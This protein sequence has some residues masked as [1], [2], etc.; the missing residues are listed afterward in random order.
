MTKCGAEPSDIIG[1]NYFLKQFH[2]FSDLCIMD[3]RVSWKPILDLRVTSDY[4][5]DSNDWSSQSFNFQ[6]LR[7]TYYPDLSLPGNRLANNGWLSF[8]R[9]YGCL[10]S[11]WFRFD[12]TARFSLMNCLIRRLKFSYNL[13]LRSDIISSAG[14]KT[15]P[16]PTLFATSAREEC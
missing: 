15:K 7:I 1:D 3:V 14:D 8:M 9:F 12:L 5:N 13:G 6:S 2:L 11:D 16:S 10:P 4:C